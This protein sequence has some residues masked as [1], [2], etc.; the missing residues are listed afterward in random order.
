M[1]HDFV[2]TVV[3]DHKEFMEDY[4]AKNGVNFDINNPMSCATDFNDFVWAATSRTMGDQYL[5]PGWK[6]DFFKMK[7]YYLR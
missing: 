2:T 7:F 5:P 3:D 4:C 6:K 1:G